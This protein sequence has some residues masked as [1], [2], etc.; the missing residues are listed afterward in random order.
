[1]SSSRP[2]ILSA[3]VLALA[4]FL[5]CSE[6]GKSTVEQSAEDAVEKTVK[7]PKKQK[8]T[9][10]KLAIGDPAPPVKIS[11]WIKGDP[12]TSYEPGKVYVVEFW[13]TWC[14]PCREG[15]PHLSELQEA[16]ADDVTIV[17]IS[18][19]DPEKIKSFMASPAAPHIAQAE[20]QTWGDLMR[21]AVGIDDN[22]ACDDAFMD[23]AG[24]TS[25]PSAFIVGK[26]AHI[27]WI[28]HPMELV[29]PVEQ[30]VTDKW[31]R[32]AYLAMQQE[33]QQRQQK[34]LEVQQQLTEAVSQENWEQAIEII[35]AN[36]EDIPNA[37]IYKLSFLIEAGKTEDALPLIGKIADEHQTDA[38]ILNSIAWSIADLGTESQPLLEKA[39]ELAK[40]ACVLT[41]YAN[42]EVLDTLALVYSKQG[43]LQEAINW[44]T[45][46][47]DA[48]PDSEKI[49]E[50][51]K[52]YKSELESSQQT[53]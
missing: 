14:P 10:P 24:R 30:I 19:Q 15:M 33:M 51:L 17:S 20:N 11:E 25:Y 12:V 1:M 29:G 22:D 3:S 45:R 16:Y 36:S 5:G 23:A 4:I 44:Q 32:K 9:G 40:R 35:E 27:E 31:D 7:K 37:E 53:S 38:V 43:N 28:G 52:A 34:L 18:R 13:A 26:D 41:G 50:N 49:Q 46:A 21:Y 39:L 47:V 48:A 42:G 8:Y 6:H 2:W